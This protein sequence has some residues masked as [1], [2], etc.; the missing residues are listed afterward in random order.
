MSY[1]GGHLRPDLYGRIPKYIKRHGVEAAAEVANFEVAH[2]QAF[3]ELIL[4]ENIDC[5]LVITRN[6]NVYLNEDEAD[7]ANETYQSLA[8]QGLSF[9]DDIHYTSGEHAEAVSWS[10]SSPAF[11]FFFI[12]SFIS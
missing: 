5:N 4:E 11:A 10:L 1:I 12:R 6:M 8:A 7:Q 9:T 2:I 3:E